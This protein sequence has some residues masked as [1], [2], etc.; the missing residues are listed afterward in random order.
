MLAEEKAGRLS[1]MKLCPNFEIAMY[2]A[3]ATGSSIVTDSFFRW[4]EIKRAIC[5]RVQTSGTTAKALADNIN[6]STFAFPQVVDDILKLSTDDAFVAYSALMREAFRYISKLDDRGQKSNY[7]KHL[8]ARFA[9]IHALAQ[10]AI[11][12]ARIPVEEARMF[13]A[14]PVG[15]I[16]DNTVNRLL[17]MSSSERHLPNVPMAFFIRGPASAMPGS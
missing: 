5:R 8:S 1:V 7:E 4:D 9:Q 17:L 14:F 11:R 16:Q 13:C 10:S 15:G 6:G 12:K 3:Q 2:L